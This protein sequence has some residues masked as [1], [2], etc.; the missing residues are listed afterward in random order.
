MPKV[1]LRRRKTRTHQ[2]EDVGEREKKYT[3]R[4]FVVKKGHVSN[5]TQ[6]LIRD[7][8]DVMSPNCAKS[9]RESKNTKIRD[10]LAV[11]GPLGVTHL[12]MFTNTD[13]TTL[14][15][16]A[17]FPHGPT[18]TFRVTKYSLCRDIQ[19]IQ[20]RPHKTQQDLHHA[21]LLVMN[22]MGGQNSDTKLMAE[23]LRNMFP[24][25]DV[26]AFTTHNCRRVVMFHMET[27]G[28]I[29]F[30]HF[31]ITT[32]MHGISR[33]V[34]K[35]MTG[36]AQ[37]S[38]EHDVADFILRGG[39]ASDSEVEDAMPAQIRR[40]RN[41]RKETENVGVNLV[42]IGPRLEL[43]PVKAQEGLLDGAI[44][45]HKFVQK[46]PEEKEIADKKAEERVAQRDKKDRLAANKAA[47]KAGLR[48][49]RK[50]KDR[51]KQEKMA[52]VFGDDGKSDDDDPM[53]GTR[54]REKYN[55]LFK[56]KTDPFGDGDGKADKTVE[57]GDDAQKTHRRRTDKEVKKTHG[58]DKDT[59]G[60]GK[61]KGKGTKGKGKGKGKRGKGGERMSI[62][63]KFH[64]GRG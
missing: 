12:T 33:S 13:T 34:Q 16:V 57:F 55:P 41:N 48:K 36:K 42:E 38:G 2:Q 14:M 6:D 52:S 20:K 8:R 54:K 46:T 18:L 64:S 23:V 63:D 27:D 10:Y 7:F 9:L 5:D 3:P 40:K 43:V 50:E 31:A 44:L 47:K 21:P 53:D 51:K 56:K 25:I 59:K 60:K 11:A 24:P 62:Q 1:G 4:S 26:D 32:K 22:G 35:L 30:R 15:R 45:F 61:G 37:V 58:K 17:R 49:A 19:S 28:T 39:Y 29:Q